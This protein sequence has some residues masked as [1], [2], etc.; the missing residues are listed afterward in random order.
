MAHMCITSV[1][2]WLQTFFHPQEDS[3]FS[4]QEL[5][6]KVKAHY[7]S[8]V[9]DG[10]VY[11]CVL[12]A[13]KSLKWNNSTKKI[14]HTKFVVGINPKTPC[15]WLKNSWEERYLVSHNKLLIIFTFIC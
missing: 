9:A 7:G 11:T 4:K 2:Q 12:K 1:Q 5:I 13:L 10:E 8:N 15:I 14:R 6:S 3:R